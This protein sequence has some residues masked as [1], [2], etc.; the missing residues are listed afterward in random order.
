[1]N[2]SVKRW[3][4]LGILVT[5][6]AGVLLHFL[7]DWTGGNVLVAGFS[8]VNESIWEHLKLLFFP[9]FAYALATSRR[10]GRMDGRFWCAVLWGVLSGLVLI[11]T[12]YYTVQGVFGMSPDWV[13]IGIFFVSV[14]FSY[15][16]IAR[17][18]V[19]ERS[20]RNPVIALG[21]LWLLALIFVIFTFK[22]PELPLFADPISGI[23][24]F[25]G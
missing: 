13:N 25:P 1:M 21:V 14:V 20:C 3:T 22:T 18:L 6:V 11:P 23:Y 2:Q 12:L 15:L 9:M 8:A 19:R 7:F 10:V 17:N 24:G 5:S 4:W 16:T